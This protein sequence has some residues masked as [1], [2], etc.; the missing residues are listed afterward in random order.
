MIW[1]VHAHFL[2][3]FAPPSGSLSFTAN[4]SSRYADSFLIIGTLISLSVS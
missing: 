4:R 1:T 2:L 3:S